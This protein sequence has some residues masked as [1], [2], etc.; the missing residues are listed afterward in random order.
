MG[1]EGVVGAILNGIP[2]IHWIVEDQQ[3]DP[4]GHHGGLEPDQPT[5][6]HGPHIKVW[7]RDHG[8]GTY[9][10]PIAPFR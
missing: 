8:R 6:C 2:E 1:L 7:P 5:S 10:G 4:V 9:T 3:V